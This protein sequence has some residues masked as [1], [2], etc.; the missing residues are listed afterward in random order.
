MA[1]LT[2]E[3]IMVGAHDRFFLVRLVEDIA[4]LLPQHLFPAHARVELLLLVE[5]GD[6]LVLVHEHDADGRLV[7]DLLQHGDPAHQG[8]RFTGPL[9]LVQEL[10]GQVIAG[11]QDPYREV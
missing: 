10:E 11:G 4:Q 1:Q 2:M 7:D 8:L 3:E 5:G 6:A 9:G